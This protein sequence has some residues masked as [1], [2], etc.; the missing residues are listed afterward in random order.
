MLDVGPFAAYCSTMARW[1]VAEQAIERHD[2]LTITTKSGQRPHPL[3]SIASQAGERCAEV[4][5]AVRPAADRTAETR[6]Y[7]AA[8]SAVEV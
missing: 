1:R 7:G 6:R 2:S 4:R 3:V 8:G 5:R